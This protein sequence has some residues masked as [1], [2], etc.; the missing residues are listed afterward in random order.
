MAK[1]QIRRGTANQWVSEDPVLV[2]GELGYETDTNKLKVGKAIA[3]DLNTQIPWTALDYFAYKDVVVEDIATTTLLDNYET[4][5]G[6][7]VY[8]R[9][10]KEVFVYDGD[11]WISVS[12]G[13]I[14]TP[15]LNQVCRE[16]FYTNTPI[17]ANDF[18]TNPTGG[19]GSRA[20]VE[21][22][23]L[24]LRAAENDYSQF[25]GITLK[26]PDLMAGV[27]NYTLELP[28]DSGDVGSLLMKG[29]NQNLIWASPFPYE[30]LKLSGR[31]KN[32]TDLMRAVN[33]GLITPV[34][35]DLY[36]ITEYYGFF[37]ATPEEFDEA[38]P[39]GNTPFESDHLLLYVESPAIGG[40]DQGSWTDLGQ[41]TTV[42]IEGPVG[43]QGVPG[44]QG[45]NKGV[46]SETVITDPTYIIGRNE[47]VESVFDDITT[48]NSEIIKTNTE[49]ALQK[50]EIIN[51]QQELENA[52]PSLNR[53]EYALA[54]PQVLQSSVA[55]IGYTAYIDLIT[56]A[57]ELFPSYE[58]TSHLFLN[59]MDINGVDQQWQNF[60][61]EIHGV[62]DS[63]TGLD[64]IKRN[65]VIEIRNLTDDSFAVFEILP[66][67]TSWSAG[68]T[69]GPSATIKIGV[70]ATRFQGAPTLN[71]NIVV[72]IYT[73]QDVALADLDLRYLRKSYTNQ[74]IS[75][76]PTSFDEG[77]TVRKKLDIDTQQLTIKTESDTTLQMNE[78]YFAQPINN[79]TFADGRYYTTRLHFE[80][81]FGLVIQ[82]T[83]LDHP[84]L[85]IGGKDTDGQEI[86]AL[87]IKAN[88][89]TIWAL[90]PFVA[91][92]P[93]L[94]DRYSEEEKVVI[95][96]LFDGL[97]DKQLITKFYVDRSIEFYTE[98]RFFDLESNENIITGNTQ[99]K[100]TLV[101]QAA[102]SDFDTASN[103]LTIWGGTKPIDSNEPGAENT[104]I[105][106]KITVGGNVESAYATQ[107]SMAN[108]AAKFKNLE[109]S[110]VTLKSAITS[111]TPSTRAVTKKYVD[112]RF[113]HVLN[114]NYYVP[115]GS[116]MLWVGSRTPAGWFFLS[117]GSFNSTTYKDLHQYLRDYVSGYRTGVLPNWDD[118]FFVQQGPNSGQNLGG[119]IPWQ[120]AV[121]KGDNK[122]V[123]AASNVP[124]P[125]LQVKS[126]IGSG[127]GSG[128][129]VLRPLYSGAG[130]GAYTYDIPIK[131]G[132]EK[133]N[134]NHS[135]SGGDEITRPDSVVGR[136]IIKADY[137]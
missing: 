91:G 71:T 48:T 53:A 112:D 87:D 67:Y 75:L 59:K 86:L 78:L 35:G 58:N 107:I 18:K 92:D 36:L 56:N 20:F 4:D 127:T 57:L 11:D 17:F 74:D 83:G 5:V 73:T 120:T 40:S 89:S 29:D 116:I 104:K 62:I 30:Q 105:N 108:A 102:Q 1:I 38:Y 6:R 129:E 21:A 81:K 110:S 137:K 47:Y 94:I 15:N 131:A 2:Q 124:M 39:L 32:E 44:P 66:E 64:G 52:L 125:V 84:L 76:V 118:R 37:F 130:G 10:T 54:S 77:I 79:L 126:G 49:L 13:N 28:S 121:P 106:F 72:K 101:V 69:Q 51:L 111:A 12:T 132:T 63:E 55:G 60:L 41:F 97:H 34:T 22:E 80:D 93:N 113:N 23:E 98:G 96:E 135:F 16:G 19:V 3:N 100:K 14:P 128:Q 50:N 99:F 9:A 90:A 117:G 42:P 7:L 123:I 27:Q 46:W 103:A 109:T 70:K 26:A 65:Y 133:G 88:G 33:E 24:N 68:Y 43:P 25:Y 114:S 119:K 61:D 115:V 45:P 82:S 8:D 31:Y 85:R 95:K 136:Y 134:H 122:I